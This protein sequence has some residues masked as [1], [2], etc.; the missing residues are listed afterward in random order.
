MLARRIGMT[1]TKQLGIC[2]SGE[3]RQRLLDEPQ[4]RLPD[5]ALEQVSR[6]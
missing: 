5:I 4:C 6:V 1:A 2:L 3:A